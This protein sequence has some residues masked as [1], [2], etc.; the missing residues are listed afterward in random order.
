MFEL[1]ERAKR[2]GAGPLPEALASSVGI[3]LLDLLQREHA[4]PPPRL[5]REEFAR[6]GCMSPEQARGRAL[7]VR[8][9]VFSAGLVLCE[10]ACGRL[11]FNGIAELVAGELT[12]PRELRPELTEALAGVLQ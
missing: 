1:L 6:L 2:A 9:D 12:A 10:L 7:D 11:P 4:Q 8:S 3:A 5:H